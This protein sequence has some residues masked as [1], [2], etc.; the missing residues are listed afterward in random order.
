M[1]IRKKILLSIVLSV[2][3]V[4]ICAVGIVYWQNKEAAI[5]N[6]AEESS[7]QLRLA[8]NYMSLLMGDARA[9]TQAL[10]GFDIMR[11]SLGRITSYADRTE[12]FKTDMSSVSDYEK[13]IC[14]VFNAF[15]TAFPAYEILYLGTSDGG[16]VLMPDNNLPAHYD[17]RDRVWFK[18]AMKTP[19]KTIM[20]EAYLSVT[21]DLVYTLAHSVRDKK[22]TLIGAV[23][24]D[25]V[26]NGLT[27]YLSKLHVGEDGQVFL[28]D[29][30]GTVLYN[31][32]DSKLNMKKIRELGIPAL[33]QMQ[34]M[35]SGIKELETPWGKDFGTAHV[36][37]EGW[38]LMT[39]VS[40]DH[41]MEDTMDMLRLMIL[42][43]VILVILLFVFGFCLSRTIA[44]PVAMLVD[45]A[46]GIAQGNFKAMPQGKAFSGELKRLHSSMTTMVEQL[47]SL[48][49]HSNAREQDAE[50]ALKKARQALDEAEEAK[51]M[52]ENARREGV[53]Q[54]AKRLDSIVAT[55]GRT[56]S[57]LHDR[58]QIITDAMSNQ[59]K[60]A[61]ET[62]DAMNQMTAAVA[63][64]AKSAS[65][66][67]RTADLARQETKQGRQDVDVVVSS[68]S[69]VGEYSDAI[70]TSVRDLVAHVDNIGQVM[71]FI[72]DVADQTNL[73]ALNAAI[74]AARA[75]EA[76]RGFAVVADEVRKLAEKTQ[77]ATIKVAEAID[78]IRQGT[79]KTDQ[80]IAKTVEAV[81]ASKELA[82]KADEVLVHIEAMVVD[83]ADKVGV[84]A[85]ASEEQSVTAEA[86]SQHTEEV[87][88]NAEKVAQTLA[89]SSEDMASLNEQTISL[90]RIMAELKQ[91]SRQ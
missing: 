79:A 43:G 65:D 30:Q 63:D 17:S 39:F 4:L 67:S 89:L 49:L 35:R 32:F 2:T 52:A 21:G 41:L 44:R 53:L 82:G 71:S 29:D 22:G 77:S 28:T 16:F 34:N 66:A 38:H 64:A 23:C 74:E 33:A 70:S 20:T 46:Q 57:E 9:V 7:E 51:R 56:G 60:R 12:S 8:G 37:P 14:H 75:G 47:E 87:K 31:T 1:S 19:D 83:T 11:E 81:R 54:T 62:A 10:S 50:E 85:T 69:N 48:V 58:T 55:L 68:L 13:E 72:N 6:F 61:S 78:V 84:I 27:E 80:L 42:V 3:V 45:A 73:L 25:I 18:D 40:K 76:G 59:L 36:T 90:Q 15:T 91:D 5:K 26:L 88:N 24:I 86:V